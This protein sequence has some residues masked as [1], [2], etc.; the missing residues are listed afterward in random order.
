MGVMT[1]VKGEAW[2][3]LQTGDKRWTRGNSEGHPY[4]R[5]GGGGKEERQA[6]DNEE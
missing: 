6:E 2:G 5:W 3:T 4:L 1:A